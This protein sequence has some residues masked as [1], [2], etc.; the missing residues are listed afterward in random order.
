[1]ADDAIINGIA[2][3]ADAIDRAERYSPFLA[4]SMMK[5]D[6]AMAFIK[7][8][9]FDAAWS[10]ALE[11]SCDDVG[12]TLRRQ[13]SAVA[14]IAAIADLSGHWDLAR[15]TRSLSDFA[16]HALNAAIG[17]AFAEYL[18]GQDARGFAVIGLGKHGGRELNYSSDIDPIFIYD[19]KTLPVPNDTDPSKIAVRIGKRIISL[20]SERTMYDYVFR[21][22]MRLRPASEIT[23][24]AISVNAAISHYESSALAWEQAAFIRAR[25][26]AG[27]IV[28]GQYFLDAIDTF[29]WRRSLDFGQ[30]DN[31]RKMSNNIRDHYS[32]GQTLG[33]GYDIKRGRGGIRECEFFAQVHQLIHGGRNASLRVSDTRLALKL[34]AQHG[35]IGDSDAQIISDGYAL[36]R[37]AEHRLQM[38]DDRQT[39][40]LP[41]SD[42]ELNNVARLHG[43]ENGDALI[44]SLQS[45]VRNIQK[46]YDILVQ[47]QDS[48]DQ[49]KLAEAGIP[50]IEQLQSMGYGA[51]ASQFVQY[52][53]SGKYRAI[54]SDAAKS[55]FETLLPDILTSLSHAPD[56]QKAL[57]SLDR[58]LEQL[59]SAINFFNL[60]Q[61][62]PGVMRLLG[63]I[64]S[65]APTLADALG[66]NAALLDGLIDSG[67]EPFH[68]RDS[69]TA[70]MQL[71]FHNDLDYQS[72]L[73]AV[74]NFVAEKRFALGVQLIEGRTDPNEAAIG[75]SALAEAAIDILTNATIRE[76]ELVHGRIDGSELLIIALGRFGGNAL[77]HA[78][79]LD[80]VFLFTGKFSA[81]SNGKRSLGAT[82]YFG[83]LSQRVIAA[84]SVPT[85]SGALYE[86]DTRLRPSGAQGLLCVSLDSFEKYQRENAWT[87]EHMALTRA[88]TILGSSHARDKVQNIIGQVLTKN[89]GNVIAHVA[90]MRREMDKHKAAISAL[91]IKNAKGGLID[92]EFMVHALQIHHRTKIDPNIE[93]AITILID[94]KLLPPVILDAHIMMSKMLILLRLI[95][96]DL[97]Q[98]SNPAKQLL[99]QNLGYGDWKMLSIRLQ[100]YQNQ[101]KSQWQDIFSETR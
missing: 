77:T 79:D 48:D 25:A 55:S 82:Q 75:Y 12:E 20:L 17:A 97:L 65:Y 40:E 100:N 78:S 39:H 7:R 26:A 95:C 14:L 47:E 36:L 69:I 51:D 63:D 5:N 62:R 57:S 83:R 27:D 2:K 37:T 35:H 67:N 81:E 74:R 76:F 54:R 52:W 86:V 71:Y 46:I 41:D 23:P 72:L 96:P 88:R 21:V 56:P 44:E 80:V 18:P 49:I 4:K 10:A 91:D 94:L 101:I 1:M 33:A 16:D 6:A 58:I 61:N 84:L 85:A 68:H 13:R 34:L 60:L 53:R 92:I 38:V 45:T 99:A 3:V 11:I 64:L 90:S 89:R 98:L 8:A 42:E 87:W 9:E 31:I 93:N 24:V 59:P 28:L 19:P 66:R 30:I 43:I 15:V 29:I 32:K 50:L 73:D 70:Q 22:D